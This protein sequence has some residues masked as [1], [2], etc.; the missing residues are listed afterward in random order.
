MQDEENDDLYGDL[1]EEQSGGHV[2]SPELDVVEE[3][4]PEAV[5][6]G[7]HVQVRGLYEKVRLEL[8][9]EKVMEFGPVADQKRKVCVE[10]LIRD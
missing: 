7:A 9:G 3:Y 5:T 6:E 8:V 10:A 4:D 2:A 1:N